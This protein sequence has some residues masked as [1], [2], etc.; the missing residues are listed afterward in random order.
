[1]LLFGDKQIVDA[2]R[3]ISFDVFTDPQEI[4]SGLNL[5]ASSA[6]QNQMNR[7]LGLYY[8]RILWESNNVHLVN[9]TISS[10]LWNMDIGQG[11]QVVAAYWSDDFR[12][13]IGYNSVEDFPNRLESWS[14]LLHPEDKDRTLNLFVQ[15]L[16]DRSGKTTYDLEY[17]L[18][19]KNRGYRWYR[20]AGNVKRNQ[21]GQAIQFIGIFV[22]VNEEH[23]GKE[24]LDRVLKRYSAIDNV[25]IQ[26]SFY[27]RLQK[28]SLEDPKNEVW[29]SEPFRKQL[30]FE[31]ETEFPNQIHSWLNRIHPEDLPA[32]LSVI[33]DGIAQQNGTVDTKYRIQHRN[34]NYLWMHA[35]IGVDR[36]ENSGRLLMAGV[37]NDVTELYHTRE[38]VEQNMNDHVRSLSECLEKINQTIAENTEAMQLVMKRQEELAQILKDSQNQMERT[39][40]AV[41]AIQNISRQTNLL[42]LNASVEAARAG[43]AGKGFAV[44]AEEVRSL[45]QN[46]DDVSKEISG[47]LGQMKEYVENV[48]QQFGMLN[49]EI[50]NQDKKMSSIQQM[51]TEID[52]TVS[53]VKDVMN[54]LLN[55]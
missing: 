8:N 6:M 43:A 5:P 32:F 7:V 31:G 11:N 29:F 55:Q 12:H 46:S 54:M 25:T 21:Q 49:E 48:A 15:T 16:E 1:M 3:E 20:A 37:I 47:D 2:L 42:S 41:S 52:T 30:G 19:T 51:V 9:E 50:S 44:V 4:P 22:D 24:A 10:G 34:G 14:N 18:K 13:M 23:E 35:V 26:G 28:H 17:R 38:L 33:N 53:G 39:S 27:I 40:Q 36:E 45:A